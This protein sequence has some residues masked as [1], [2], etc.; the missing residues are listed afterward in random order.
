[1]HGDT[2]Y[3]R[4]A[5]I[6]RNTLTIVTGGEALVAAGGVFNGYGRLHGLNVCAA[7]PGHRVR[8]IAD[9]PHNGRG[10]YSLGAP[11]ATYGIFYITTD[12]GHVVAIAD[13]AV[14]PPA[15]VRCSQV[16][17]A[18]ASCAVLGFSLVYA[19][20]VL[21][22]VALTDGA[23]VR[24][25]ATSLLSRTAACLSRRR[26][27]T[28]TCCRPETGEAA[29]M[30]VCLEFASIVLASSAAFAQQAKP[31]PGATGTTRG[32]ASAV[33]FAT[34]A[35]LPAPGG[36][37]QTYRLA[38]GDVKV[39]GSKRVQVPPTGFYVA[40]LVTND[41]ISVEGGQRVLRHTGE[42]PRRPQDSRWYWSHRA[43]TTRCCLKCSG[44]S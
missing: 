10:G 26:A 6:W 42:F 38:L 28:S 19:P 30:K 9:A 25:C 15:G 44:S 23:Y 4:P 31:A 14:A 22:D 3:K 2:D 43:R 12:Q 5:A 40:T 24:D 21:A 32:V 35:E 11:S 17:M 34:T 8:W 13:P 39:S 41:V 29:T 36:Q 20:A 37:V 18:V 1:M 7:S 27:D 16:L 33:R